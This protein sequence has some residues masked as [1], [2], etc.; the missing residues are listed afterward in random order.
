M[1]CARCRSDEGSDVS[2]RMTSLSMLSD[3]GELEVEV[4]AD[5]EDEGVEKEN[6]GAGG[7]RDDA[8]KT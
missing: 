3:V 7:R 4:E 5:V 2:P 1:P 6:D 8:R